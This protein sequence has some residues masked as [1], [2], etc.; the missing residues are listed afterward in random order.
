MRLAPRADPV[1]DARRRRR[2]RERIERH[3]QLEVVPEDREEGEAV[4]AAEVHL[5]RGAGPAGVHLRVQV[6]VGAQELLLRAPR[7]ERRRELG[8]D[9]L[10][11]ARVQVQEVPAT[12]GGGEGRPVSAASATR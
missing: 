12:E 7:D 2:L 11:E 6:L 4:A 9:E 10:L 5:V 3:V 8:E 1:R